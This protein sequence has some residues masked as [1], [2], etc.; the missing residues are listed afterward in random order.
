MPAITHRVGLVCILCTLFCCSCS[1]N[2]AIKL[3]DPLYKELQLSCGSDFEIPMLTTKWN[4]ESVQ[5]LPSGETMPDKD[6]NPMALTGNGTAEAANGWLTLIRKSNDKFVLKLNENFDKSNERK[7]IICIY[8]DG[9]RDYITVVQQAAPAYELV[10]YEFS[11]INE[12]RKIYTSDAE[13]TRITLNNNTPEAVWKPTGYIFEKVV[14]SS[15]FESDVYGAFDWIPDKGIEVNVP[16]LIIDDAIR[17]NNRC[18][19]KKGISTIPFIKNIPNGSKILV[20]PYETI[21]LK[22]EIT[23]CKR[24]CNYTFTIRNAGSGTQFKINGVWTQI[25]PISSNTI[26]F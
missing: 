8:E 14:E 6:G 23:Y 22:G 9:Q 18:V 25:I 5:Y 26:S 21:Y 3:V 1:K 12:Q 10:K 15:V 7:F 17:W 16:E 2:E 19:Y 13:C 4:I 24:I 11:E 20:P